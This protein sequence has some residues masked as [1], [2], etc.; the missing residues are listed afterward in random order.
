MAGSIC[1]MALESGLDPSDQRSK[2]MRYRFWREGSGTQNLI[3]R[4]FQASTEL[5]YATHLAI[6]NGTAVQGSFGVSG[7]ISDWG[8][9]VVELEGWKS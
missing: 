3:V 9:L 2:E 4:L 7:T 8:T 6:T 5:G 1:R